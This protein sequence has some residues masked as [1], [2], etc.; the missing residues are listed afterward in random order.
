VLSI[1]GSVDITDELVSKSLFPTKCT[2]DLSQFQYPDFQYDPNYNEP[3]SI[4]FTTYNDSNYDEPGLRNSHFLL[5]GES[6]YSCWESSI[7]LV[8]S[9]RVS[10]L[11]CVY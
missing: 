6:E 7:V 4:C 3:V 1:T 8:V 11:A 2:T 5:P 10:Y 9:C